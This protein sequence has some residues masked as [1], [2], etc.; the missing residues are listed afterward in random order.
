M[1]REII[2][3]KN[4]TAQLETEF[5]VVAIESDKKLSYVEQQIEL[6]QIAIEEINQNLKYL[7]SRKLSPRRHIPV[8]ISHP[9]IRYFRQVGIRVMYRFSSR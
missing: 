9:F 2:T 7:L 6:K 3:L 5:Q 4:N 8:R 1:E